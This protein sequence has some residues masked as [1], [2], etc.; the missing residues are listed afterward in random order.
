ML[1]PRLQSGR[2][3]P[4]GIDRQFLKLMLVAIAV[5][6]LV[7]RLWLAFADRMSAASNAGPGAAFPAA[8]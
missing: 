1:F 4:K 7:S 6:I 2:R 3:R 5:V 8:R